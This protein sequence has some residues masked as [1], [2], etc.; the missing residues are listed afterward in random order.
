MEKRDLIETSIDRLAD[1]LL[2]E[3]FSYIETAG[4]SFRPGDL[5]KAVQS[6]MT[7]S[8]VVMPYMAAIKDLYKSRNVIDGITESVVKK[9]QVH[10]QKI[11]WI[12]DTFDH[13]N[14]VSVT[15]RN[16]LE[17]VANS[18]F[19]DVN[20]MVSVPDSSIP[21]RLQD[22]VLNIP[23]IH[24]YTPGFYNTVTVR[25][26]SLIRSIDA[27]EQFQPDKI[28]IST[29][30]PL[31]MIG[32]IAAKLLE[33]PATA[34][35]H[36]DFTF[37]AVKMM[38]DTFITECIEKY[39]RFF[40]NLS[41]FIKVP[42]YNYI[43]ILKNRNFDSGR[44]SLLGRA[45]DCARFSVKSGA[46]TRLA[47]QYGI[48][49]GFTFLYVGRVSE[50]KN[51]RF[52]G[53]IY[54]ELLKRFPALNLVI[55][56]D[57]PDLEAFRSRMK[58]QDRV[59]FTGRLSQ[60]QMPLL[61]SGSDALLFPSVTDTFGMVVLEAHACGLP[62]LVSDMGGPCE[63]VEDG[64]TGYVITADHLNRWV[65]TASRLIVMK[66]RRPSQFQQL[67]LNARKHVENSFSWEQNLRDLFDSSQKSR[68]CDSDTDSPVIF[69]KTPTGIRIP[70]AA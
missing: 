53:D 51:I 34:I 65:E 21:D 55:A 63:I 62:A 42:T 56:G 22:K 31:G 54:L 36:T 48:K 37:Q 20:A 50:D 32:L 66:E 67:K 5:M 60:V 15:M 33:I 38:G 2:G 57:G 64:H 25:F 18:N 29:P 19:Y 11:L 28:V 4:R 35:Y 27:I 41:D 6:L 61:Y 47:E 52:I 23:A 16:V 17:R 40:Y 24:E 44:M 10:R 14:G 30:G 70:S 7:G 59:V 58:N 8:S 3:S 46:A 9:K 45:V 12:S 13:L 49:D 26:P 43:E 68:E 69:S 1:T 39:M